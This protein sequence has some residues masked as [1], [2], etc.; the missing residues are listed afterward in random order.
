MVKCKNAD[1]LI[2]FKNNLFMWCITCMGMVMNIHIIF[3]W[4]HANYMTDQMLCCAGP[5]MC[6]TVKKYKFQISFPLNT[7][8]DAFQRKKPYIT[9]K[10]FTYRL[11]RKPYI[12]CL[13]DA[14]WAT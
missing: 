2:K 5:C 10:N 1:I 14:K 4:G 6:P 13:R 3:I 8:W 9:M 12:T 7:F 11:K